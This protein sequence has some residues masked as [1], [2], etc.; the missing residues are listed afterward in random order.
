MRAQIAA[1]ELPQP[2]AARGAGRD[3]ERDPGRSRDDD[4]G[5]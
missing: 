5:L 3:G 1:G 2:G 4:L